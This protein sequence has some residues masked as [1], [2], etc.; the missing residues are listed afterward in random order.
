MSK[1]HHGTFRGIAADHWRGDLGLTRLLWRPAAL[2]LLVTAV[3]VVLVVWSPSAIAPVP[4]F[5]L[6]LAAWGLMLA[7]SA[8]LCMGVFRAGLGHGRRGGAPLLGYAVAAAAALAMV[9][10]AAMGPGLAKTDLGR[11]IE[12][13]QVN[14]PITTPIR[15]INGGTELVFD[16]TIEHGAANALRQAAAQSPHVKRIRLGG[17]G[18]ELREARW[19]RD[20][21]ASKGWDTHAAGECWSGCVI[22]YLGGARRTLDPAARMGFHSASVWP[23]GTEEGEAAINDSIAREMIDRGVDPVF[24]RRAWRKSPDGMWFPSHDALIRTGLVHAIAQP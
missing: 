19:M 16:G 13:V 6:A 15:S 12:R 10:L 11:A 7:L 14:M 24:A 18:G 2:F 20:F 4:S 5:F 9:I 23:F 22:A 17:M 8:W 1:D 21:I 3:C